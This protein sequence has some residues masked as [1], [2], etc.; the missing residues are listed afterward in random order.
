MLT[1]PYLAGVG[2]DIGQILHDSNNALIVL[3]FWEVIPANWL[4]PGPITM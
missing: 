1:Q 2:A 3:E 4:S